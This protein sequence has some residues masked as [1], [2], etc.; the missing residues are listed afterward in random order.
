VFQVTDGSKKDEQQGSNEDTIPNGEQRCL[1]AFCASEKWK[2]F[3]AATIRVYAR[4]NRKG[5]R[6]SS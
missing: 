3:Q 6:G 4:K 2:C 1:K 5:N